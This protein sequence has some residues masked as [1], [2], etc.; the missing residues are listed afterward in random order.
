M[1]SSSDA[2]TAC[3]CFTGAAVVQFVRIA[4]PPDDT[5]VHPG[6]KLHVEISVKS[7][8]HPIT[9]RYWPTMEAAI[10]VAVVIGLLLCPFYQNDI[11]PPPEE[12]AG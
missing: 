6:K 10:E 8:V 9:A 5:V 2:I 12:V 11:C 1:H 4:A 7:I 3:L